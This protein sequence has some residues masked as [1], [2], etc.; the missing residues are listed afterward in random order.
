MGEPVDR[1]PVTSRVAIWG[2][3]ILLIPILVQSVTGWGADHAL[4]I[5]DLTRIPVTLLT[6][7][8][9][10]RLLRGTSLSPR[11]YRAWRWLGAGFVCQF[12]AHM[13]S[14]IH[15]ILRQPPDYPNA[16]DYLYAIAIP[17]S[18][19]GLLLLASA[20]RSRAERMK[21]LIDSITV[22]VGASMAIWYLEIA[23]IMQIPG[24]DLE[25]LVFSAAVPVLDLVLIFALVVLVMR[26]ATA[27]TPVRLLAASAALKV[28]ADTSYTI[29]YVQFGIALAPGTWPFLLWAAADLLALLA[30]HHQARER[31]EPLPDGHHPKR[32]VSW[33]P[34]GAIVLA[35]GLLAFVGRHQSL[36]SLGGMILG[37][38]VLTALVIG[39]QILAQHDNRR[40]AVTDP[41]T[42]LSNR[43]LLTDRLADMIRQPV[44]KSRHSALLL[45]DLDRFKPINDTHGHEAGDAV[46]V[47]VGSVLRS[48][49]RSGDTAGRLGGDEFALLLPDLPS[50]AMAESIAQRLIEALRT[51]VV[52]GEVLLSVE[53]SIGVAFRDETVTSPEQLIAN[54]DTAMYAIKRSGRGDYRIYHADM[55]VR[56]R[57]NELRHALDR[58]EF[59]VHYQPIVSLTGSSDNG[60]EALVRWNHP[61]RG[62]LPP[63]AFLTAAEDTG[64][65]IPIGEWVLR[66]SCGQMVRW[67]RQNPLTAPSWLSVNLSA[68]QVRHPGLADMFRAVL[69]D[70]AFPAA[71]LMVELPENSLLEPD[72]RTAANLQALHALGVRLAVDNFGIG[73]SAIGYFK[74]VPLSVIKLDR[75]LVA[76]IDVDPDSHDVIEALMR[77][78][79]AFKLHSVAS[80]VENAGQADRL[81]RMGCGYGQGYHLGRPMTAETITGLLAASAYPSSPAEATIVNG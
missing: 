25:M 43:A 24:A 76:R 27:A 47:A 44:S 10:L 74:S 8:L 7:V 56:S 73:H 69:D 59:I 53:A 50:R 45:I 48:V 4:L 77:L 67:Q 64:A 11:R 37:A 78:A 1:P 60:V 3:G 28:L 2:C 66:E 68:S 34:Y 32:L 39:R 80:G 14:L 13:A 23:P 9:S 49:I 58:H 16:A 35:Y 71:R 52:F 62:L 72:E 19:V 65:L 55:D 15:T 40:L 20:P 31:D 33:L 70:T 17:C 22:L 81:V 30:V 12:A 46:L 57:D 18:V 38:I 79:S 29:T 6:A 51:P 5:N 26:R 41:L 21:M 61:D 54:A 36:Y 42:K 75:T 63:A